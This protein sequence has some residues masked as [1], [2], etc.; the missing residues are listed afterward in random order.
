[1]NIK[2][3]SIIVRDDC[4]PRLQINESK[5]C[6][7]AE[8]IDVLPPIVISQ[9]NILVDGC[10]RLEA[11][12]QNNLQEIE[13]IIKEIHVDNI[14]ERAIELNATHGL[15]LSYKE[16][17]QLSI[18][19]F[20]GSNGKH[21]VSILSVSPDCLNK[22]VHAKREILKEQTEESILNDYLTKGL[23]QKEIAEQYCISQSQIT[24]IKEKNSEKINLLISNKD[25]AP[26]KLK[27]KYPAIAGFTPKSINVWD[28]VFTDEFNDN[29]IS[30][31]DNVLVENIL[32]RYSKPF[33]IIVDFTQ[34]SKQICRSFYRRFVSDDTITKPPS[35]VIIESD[36][37]KRYLSQIE[38][39]KSK[40]KNKGYVAILTSNYKQPF[41][42]YEDMKSIESFLINNIILPYPNTIDNKEIINQ[43][44]ES[45]L[46]FSFAH[47]S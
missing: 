46:I 17:Q 34:K 38:T 20:N 10:H 3:D 26:L 33:D 39:L 41:Q 44:Y 4:Y 15:Q 5:V 45:I 42:V 30:K 40:M 19:L 16:K 21:L 8:N 7:Y 22:W 12:K 43:G 18:K 28:D 6:E 9:E 36:E 47:K 32:Y 35:L 2:I 27:E 24:E 1:M 25:K 13:C 23:T 29:C 11:H 14:L 31:N 37:D